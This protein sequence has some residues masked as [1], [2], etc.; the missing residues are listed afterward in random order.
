ME[1]YVTSQRLAWRFS[2]CNSSSLHKFLLYAHIFLPNI[3]YASHQI[4]TVNT[5]PV[6]WHAV[7]MII[8]WLDGFLQVHGAVCECLQV[9]SVI[10]IMQVR[11]P[12]LVHICSS[13]LLDPIILI[14]LDAE[15][16]QRKLPQ[17][18]YQK[19]GHILQVLMSHFTPPITSLLLSLILTL[20]LPLKKPVN[21]LLIH[22]YTSFCTTC[23]NF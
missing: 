19:L 22:D 23:S 11:H 13:R 9:E 4:V 1:R 16:K 17:G 18:T 12:V 5:S 21:Q 6:P 3:C 7:Y 10:L 2:V 8:Y 15:L 14:E 20:S